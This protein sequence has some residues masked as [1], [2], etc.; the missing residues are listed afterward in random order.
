MIR[1]N[2]DKYLEDYLTKYIKECYEQNKPMDNVMHEKLKDLYEVQNNLNLSPILKSE[3]TFVKETK[4]N[5]KRKKKVT[6][7]KDI[8]IIN[9]EVW[10]EFNIDVS[11]CGGCP[12]WDKHTNYDEDIYEYENEI[13]NIF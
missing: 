4:A 12:E 8:D 11:E 10:K 7:K 1:L 2:E 13:C 9:I 5:Y 6:I 3:K